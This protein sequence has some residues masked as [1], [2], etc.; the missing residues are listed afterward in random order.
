MVDAVLD[1]R[2]GRL[3][4]PVVVLV[5]RGQ[6]PR[7]TL[8]GR[9]A[10]DPQLGLHLGQRGDGAEGGPD[11]TDEADGWVGVGPDLADVGG[12]VGCGVWPVDGVVVVVVFSPSLSYFCCCCCCCL[13]PGSSRK[14]W[15][16]LFIARAEYGNV[17]LDFRFFH[18][19]ILGAIIIAEVDDAV[20]IDVLGQ[21]G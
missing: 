17:R 19:L 1:A 11:E 21:R 16:I 7:D 9:D 5:G 3:A 20:L 6:G 2:G 18:R 8:R 12:G 4:Q 10:Q 13:R 15:E 14:E